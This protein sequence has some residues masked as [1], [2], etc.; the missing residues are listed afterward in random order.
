MTVVLLSGG[1]DGITMQYNDTRNEG[2][3]RH[4]HLMVKDFY[5]RGDKKLKMT[6]QARTMYVC[7]SSVIA[8][9]NTAPRLLD[10]Q[11]TR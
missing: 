10:V 9:F 1:Y 2:T 8:V 4:T 7:R 5:R 3:V 11:I 6:S